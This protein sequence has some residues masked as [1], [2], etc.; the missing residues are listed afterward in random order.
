L[1]RLP[2]LLRQQY[3]MSSLLFFIRNLV[4]RDRSPRIGR[5]SEANKSTTCC[6]AAGRA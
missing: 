2:A 3:S 4:T 6:F 5:R 1:L